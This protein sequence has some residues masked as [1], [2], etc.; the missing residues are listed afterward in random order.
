RVA[1]SK[2]SAK[3]GRRGPAHFSLAR[4]HV[5][6]R[7]P[8]HRLDVVESFG[9]CLFDVLLADVFA[10]TDETLFAA[11]LAR[12]SY[13][14]VI[15]QSADSFRGRG[16]FAEGQ[17]GSFAAS[18]SALGNLLF[19]VERS[20]GR[21]CGEKAEDYS[22]RKPAAGFVAETDACHQQQFVGGHESRRET[23]QV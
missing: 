12:R 19:Q 3:C 7:V 10:E 2:S 15:R 8:L 14:G 22:I 20:G 6:R 17:G 13:Y 18:L 11:R 23:E 16:S 1:P 9:N 5:Y 21:A 4:P